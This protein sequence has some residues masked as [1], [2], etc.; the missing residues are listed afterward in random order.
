MNAHERELEALDALDARVVDLAKDVKLLSYI[1]WPMEL[2]DTF[3]EGWRKGRPE[4]PRPPKPEPALDDA[5]PGLEELSRPASDHPVARFIA[6]TAESYLNAARLLQNA[7]TRAFTEISIAMYGK[8][9]DHVAPGGLTNLAAAEH[10]LQATEELARAM[11]EEEEESFSAAQVQARMRASF[12]PFFGKGRVAVVL[13][14][15]L[16]SKAAAGAERVRLRTSARFTENDVR[17]L[18]EHEGFVHSATALNGRMQPRL[19]CLSLNAPRTTATQEGL[20][21]FAELLTNSIDLAR[22][23]RLAL[24][25]G[26]I[27]AALE[28]AD[29]IEVFRYFLE[30]GQSESESYFSAARIFRGGDP[31]G[32]SVF[33]KDAVYL[34]GLVRTKTF[35]IAALAERKVH[36]PQILFTG[37]LTWGDV[38]ELEPFFESGWITPGAYVPSWVLNRQSLAANLA[39]YSLTNTIPMEEVGFDD[40]SVRDHKPGTTQRWAP[41]RLAGEPR[42]PKTK[43][44]TPK[45]PQ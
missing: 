21:T 15:G 27:Q 42:T 17:Q 12:D 35:L 30:A 37:R 2:A 16:A 22:L 10:L 5:I 38:A 31:K 24:R 7:G 43:R 11:P 8:P 25:I 26:G 41:R 18:I 14:E 44:P 32:G 6:R 4:I 3:L 19:S 39:F 13:D 9:E 1:A 34:R 33:T 20:A 45:R 36:Y 29:F 23:R 40:Y 28:G